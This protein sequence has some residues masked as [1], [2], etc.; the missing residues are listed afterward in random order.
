MYVCGDTHTHTSKHKNTK[1]ETI[2]H[3]KEPR[4]HK[5]PRYSEL[6]KIAYKKIPEKAFCVASSPLGVGPALKHG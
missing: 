2:I 5:M 4:I 3:S 1:S 6:R